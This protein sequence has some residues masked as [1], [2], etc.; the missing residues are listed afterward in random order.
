MIAMLHPPR[1]L[2]LPALLLLGLSAS[3]VAIADDEESS[4]ALTYTQAQALHDLAAVI[5]CRAPTSVGEPLSRN[6]WD[7]V[8]GDGKRAKPPFDAWTVVK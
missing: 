1:L 3:P 8:L 6:V 5:E 4:P 2:L 7:V